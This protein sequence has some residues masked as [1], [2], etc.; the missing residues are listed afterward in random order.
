MRMMKVKAKISGC[1]RSLPGPKRFA[2]PRGFIDTARKR[3]WGIIE[4]L[5]LNTEAVVQRLA[6]TAP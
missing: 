5:A 3:G 6:A 4:T 2:T 1:F